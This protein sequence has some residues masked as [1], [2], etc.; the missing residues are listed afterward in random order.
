MTKR[1]LQLAAAVVFVLGLAGASIALASGGDK[2]HGKHGKSNFRAKLTGFQETPAIVTT[3]RGKLRLSVT[4][5]EITFRLDYS[6]LSGPPLV[7]HIHVGQKS[8]AGAVSVFFCGGGGKPACP[9]STSGSVSGTITAANVIG[10]AAQGV[11]PGNLAALETAIRAGV[12]YA[13]MHT[14]KYPAGEIRGQIKG[15]HRDDDDGGHR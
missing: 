4:D 14:A 10:P 2:G 8:V 1:R 15:G 6:G 9:A 5:S 7:A 13:N 3:G 12:A 11:D